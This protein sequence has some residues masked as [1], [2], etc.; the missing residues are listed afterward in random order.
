I[1][2]A[3]GAFRHCTRCQTGRH[4]TGDA[5]KHVVGQNEIGEV[6]LA[7]VGDNKAEQNLSAGFNVR[8]G[9]IIRIMPGSATINRDILLDVY[10]SCGAGCSGYSASLKAGA[11]L[12]CRGYRAFRHVP[13]ERDGVGAGFVDLEW[14][15]PFDAVDAGC[16]VRAEADRTGRTVSF[17]DELRA[18]NRNAEIE[19]AEIRRCACTR[20]NVG[21]HSL[22]AACFIDTAT[23]THQKA[24]EQQAVGW[25]WLRFREADNLDVD[26]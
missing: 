26:G 16:W 20:H 3:N 5:I 8:P 18:A 4:G 12:D 24:V 19:V 14:Q 10:R 2:G 9:G 13:P 23:V 17:Y 6:G 21:K 15:I 1:E 22:I 7:G 25:L 11:A